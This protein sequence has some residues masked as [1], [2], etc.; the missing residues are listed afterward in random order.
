MVALADN[1]WPCGANPISDW[2]ELSYRGSLTGVFDFSLGQCP[3]LPN[4]YIG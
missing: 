2:L 4:I 3:D 1:I